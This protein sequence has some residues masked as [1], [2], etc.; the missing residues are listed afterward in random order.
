MDR[1]FQNGKNKKQC[2]AFLANKINRKLSGVRHGCWRNG[3]RVRHDDDDDDGPFV[4]RNLG[5]Y[6]GRSKEQNASSENPDVG[7]E[8]GVLVRQGDAD[9]LQQQQQQQQEDSPAIRAGPNPVSVLYERLPS[10]ITLNEAERGGPSDE[11]QFTFEA[12]RISDG[13]VLGTGRACSIKEAKKVAAA[14][15]MLFLDSE[16]EQKRAKAADEDEQQRVA[17]QGSAERTSPH[18]VSRP[19]H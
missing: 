1:L 15:A 17:A 9:A 7:G 10:N 4:P 19:R 8:G 12:T 2:Q 5:P 14:K 6:D 18:C 11:P 3:E 16:S 13:A